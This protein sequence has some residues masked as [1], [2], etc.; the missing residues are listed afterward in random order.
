MA[1]HLII[2]LA[3]YVGLHAIFSGKGRCPVDMTSYAGVMEVGQWRTQRTISN[4]L[5]Q[6]NSIHV[7]PVSNRN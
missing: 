3:L 5:L 6:Y 2:R 7:L 4:M 1:H